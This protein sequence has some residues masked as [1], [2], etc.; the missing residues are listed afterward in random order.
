[1]VD[2]SQYNPGGVLH[3]LIGLNSRSVDGFGMMAFFF[4]GN[5]YIGTDLADPSAT[6]TILGV[7]RTSVTLSYA[8]YHPN[9]AM[10]CPTGG[11]AAV[12]YQWNGT[13]LTPLSAY[14]PS[15]PGAPLSRR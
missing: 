5:E 13:R 10:C 1:M 7:S 15:D 11:T 6:I 14:P 2:A 4:V 9:D 8:L 3:A 12:T